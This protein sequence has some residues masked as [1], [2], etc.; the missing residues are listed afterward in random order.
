MSNI[1]QLNTMSLENTDSHNNNMAPVKDETA[2]EE[3]QFIINPPLPRIH[4]STGDTQ[5]FHRFRD[6]A[7]ELQLKIFKHALPAPRVV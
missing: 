4:K 6:L 7:R 1:S 5:T 2:D 3:V